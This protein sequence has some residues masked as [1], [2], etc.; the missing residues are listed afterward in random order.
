MKST[1]AVDFGGT[2]IKIGITRG[3]E[4]LA[5][6]T[7][8]AT[9]A[10]DSPVSIIE[11]MCST[12]RT[13]LQQHPDAG[14]IGLGMPGW[15]DFHRGVLYQLTNV[16]VWNHE[17]AVRDIMQ[18]ELGLPVVLDND[19]NCMAYAEWKLGA[20][21]GMESLACLT[22]GTGIGGGIIIHNRMLRGK[23]VS[24][25]EVG[26]TSIDWQGIPGPFGNK[27]AIEEYIGNQEFATSAAAAYAAAGMPRRKDECSPYQLVQ[28]ATQGCPIAGKLYEDYAHRLATLIM[29]LMYTFVPEAFIIGGGVAKAGDLL[30]RPLLSSLKSQLFPVH[31]AALRV[32][33][34]HF[35]ADAGLIGAGLMA[36][37]YLDGKLL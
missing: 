32:L 21:Q 13:L 22:L 19:A 4:I 33:P 35:G 27:G 8:L 31:Y 20:G 24:A 3:A 14:A 37:D 10:Y 15:T 6:A 16:P 25:A 26:Q 17:V 2:G 11:A 7:P 23:T 12:I 36:A 5:K 30:M 18:R 28:A 34:A 9:A 1:V 29:N